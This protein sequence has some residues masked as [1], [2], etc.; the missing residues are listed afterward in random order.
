MRLAVAQTTLRDDPRRIDEL[1]EAACEV[2]R[3]MLRAHDEGAKLAHF[4]EGATCSPHKLVMSI[5]GPNTVGPSDWDGFEWTVVRDELA[6]TAELAARLKLWTVLGSVHQLTPPTR[7]YNSLYVISDQGVV[8]TR[9]DER[10]LS[11]TKIGCAL[12]MEAHYPEVFGEY[13][14]LDV[15]C[16]LFSSTGEGKPGGAQSFATE[17]QGHAAA[18]SYWVSFSV[19]AQQS[20]IA[21]A[22]V[23]SPGGKWVAR[24]PAD[25]TAAI[26]VVDLDDDS[27]EV[28]AALQHARPWRRR[29]RAG[30]YVPHFVRADPRSDD[31]ATF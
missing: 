26:V 2:R 31:R 23:V 3:L 22:G 5:D 20:P 25:G 13:E 27:A 9:Y 19:G 11:N 16:V 15:D 4:P 6:N 1:R 10:L 28:A 8:V 30:L 17:V 12:G 21:S 24:C 14:R 29:A 18:N 7:P